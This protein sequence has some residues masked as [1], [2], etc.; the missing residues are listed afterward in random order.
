M[1]ANGT[2][3]STSFENREEEEEEDDNRINDDF[4]GTL[5]VAGTIVNLRLNNYIIIETRLILF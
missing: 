2:T 5:E 1:Q 3:E 4:H